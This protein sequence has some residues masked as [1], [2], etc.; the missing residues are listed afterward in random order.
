MNRITKAEREGLVEEAKTLLLA[1]GYDTTEEFSQDD[2]GAYIAG[3]ARP[4]L[5]KL[6]SEDNLS[7]EQAR[8]VVAKALRQLRYRD[9]KGWRG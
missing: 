1:N 9:M 2:P 5:E 3:F 8:G 6:V 4:I 7:K